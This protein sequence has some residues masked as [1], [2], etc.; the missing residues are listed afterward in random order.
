MADIQRYLNLITSE[1][2]GKPKFT[3]WLTAPLSILD[4]GAT[5]ANNFETYFDLD[6]AVGAQ[7]DVLGGIIG[8]SR[9][10][11]F[12]PTPYQIVS[13]MG[14]TQTISP[15]P[16]LN[17]DMYRLLLC[18]KILRNTWDGTIPSLYKMWSALFADAYLIIKDNQDMTMNAL[19]IGLSS[20]TQRDLISH[21]YIIPKPQGVQINY[22]YSA[23][24]YFA[25][26]IE[27]TDLRGY[28][29]GYWAQF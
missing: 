18:A 19:I 12:Q 24:P 20:Q 15:S 7:L 4:D 5:L 29:E 23:N 21:G 27:S 11:N 9:T 17:D 13:V 22:S 6:S 3:A 25:Y 14:V 26:G 10:V 28:G 2:R 16:T 1:H 8:V